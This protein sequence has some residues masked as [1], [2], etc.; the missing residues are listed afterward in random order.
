[1]GEE[2]R[3]SDRQIIE[4]RP[5]WQRSA[6]ENKNN[7]CLVIEWEL[8]TLDIDGQVMQFLYGTVIHD[9]KSRWVTGDY[10]FTSKI[11]KLD[12]ENGLVQTR[13]SLYCLSGDGQEVFPTLEEA[14]KIRMTGQSL[15]VI[16]GIEKQGFKFI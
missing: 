2:E 15:G 4:A 16:R 14:V 6:E 11:E 7:A 12:L 5:A 8:V 13:N 9:Y 10:V 1:M 3:M